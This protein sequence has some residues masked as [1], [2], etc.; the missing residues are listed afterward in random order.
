MEPPSGQ[1]LPPEAQED[2][3]SVEALLEVDVCSA[4][5]QFSERFQQQVIRVQDV[6]NGA[7]AFLDDDHDGHDDL[8]ELTAPSAATDFD[9]SPTCRLDNQL[10]L[11]DMGSLASRS[12]SEEDVSRL[13]TATSAQEPTNSAEEALSPASPRRRPTALANSGSASDFQPIGAEVSEEKAQQ[14]KNDVR[15]LSP[16]HVSQH[17]RTLGEIRLTSEPLSSA[18]RLD[19]EPS[20]ADSEPTTD[21]SASADKSVLAARLSAGLSREL[22]VR[23]SRVDTLMPLS[24]NSAAYSTTM[25]SDKVPSDCAKGGGANDEELA[26]FAGV[27]DECDAESGAA[28]AKYSEAAAR[29]SANSPAPP[30]CPFGSNVVLER[31]SLPSPTSPSRQAGATSSKVLVEKL[32]IGDEIEFSSPVQPGRAAC[33]VS[34]P[35]PVFGADVEENELMETGS[36]SSSEV[37]ASMAA[38][39]AGVASHVGCEDGLA[40]AIMTRLEQDPPEAFT[41]DSAESLALAQGSRDEVRSDGSDSG[42]GSEMPGDHCAS[43]PQ[44]ESDSET[45]FLDRIPD[46]ILSDKD[47]LSELDGFVDNVPRAVPL[48]PILRAPAKSSLKRRLTDCLEEADEPGTKRLNVDDSTG[49]LKK[50]RNIQFDAV[51]VYYFPRAQGFTCVPS[52]GGSTLGMSATHTHAER[53]SLQEHALEQRR[54]HKARLA[55]L[56]AQRLAANCHQSAN[57]ETASSSE[58]PSDDTDDELSDAE[59]LDIDNYYFLQPVPTWQRR[60]LLRA[61]GVRRI[62]S[63]EKDECRDIRASREHCG[64]ACKGYCDPESCPCSRANVKCQVDRQG[65]PCGCSR[66]GCANSSG[67]IEFNPVRVRTHFIHTLMRLELEK[68]PHRDEEQQHQHH[69]QQHQDTHHSHHQ[70][71]LAVPMSSNVELQNDCL[72][73]GFTG[74]HYD[75]HDGT[76]TDSLDLYTMRDECYSTD[77]CLVDNGQNQQRKLH[78]EFA[79]SFQHYGGQGPSMGFQQNPYVDYETYQNLPSTSRSPFQPQF[80][81]VTS[82]PGFSHYGSY[83][84]DS[85]SSSA[86]NCHQTHTLMHQQQDQQQHNNVIYDAPFAHEDLSGSQYTNLNSIQPMNSVVQQIGKLESFSELLSSRYSYYGDIIDQQQNQQL[87]GAYGA[88]KMDMDKNETVVTGQPEQLDEED[89]DE[90]FGE[91]IKKSMV[92]T[93]SA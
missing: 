77:D 33:R 89:C 27:A 1:Q 7:F 37:L 18:D 63:F 68:K 76:R 34:S 23:L 59:D 66:D 53:F 79:Q 51:T 82:N 36:D 70:N 80:Q 26:L 42:L 3:S 87:H 61:A 16:V 39:A 22:V 13:D 24:P 58:D 83:S 60:A 65:F 46:D 12:S 49:T 11:Q 86:S 28:G 40:Q 52:Q 55:Q 25:S 91:I 72:A 62:D 74:L 30:R 78:S 50:K 35:P 44:H 31:C 41:E 32:R 19:A 6:A 4:E 90:N 64:C 14:L 15:R 29:T 81:P 9:S 47:K 48:M 10:P 5:L 38:A 17:E 45:S 93:V 8:G 54:L 75:S 2:S 69:Q 88:T 67:R 71:R 56:R 57:N 73:G 20:Y 92:E 84:Q 21:A 85:S 43:A